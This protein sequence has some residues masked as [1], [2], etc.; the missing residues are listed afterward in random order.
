LAAGA[1]LLDSGRPQRS[2]LGRT[3]GAPSIGL[4]G[5]VGERDTE[6]RKTRH[7]ATGAAHRAVRCAHNAQL[8][9]E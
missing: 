6:Q 5:P 7:S 9:G 1:I 4:A 2:V 3:G 8:F